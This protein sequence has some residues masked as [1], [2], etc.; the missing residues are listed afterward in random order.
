[1]L[2]TTT[3][4]LLALTAGVT[5]AASPTLASGAER[6]ITN[7]FERG[8]RGYHTFRIPA[9][10][11]C[12]DGT[13]LAFAEGRVTGGGDS[14]NIDLVMKRSADNGLTWGALQVVADFG[15]GTIGNPSA[16]VD[17]ASGAVILLLTASPDGCH[18][19]D[20]RSGKKGVRDP[21][22]MRSTDSGRRWTSPRA[23][24]EEGDRPDWRWYATGPGH[25]IQLTEGAHAG[26]IVAPANHSA[27][28]GS[29]NDQLGSHLLLSDDAGIT[30][31]IGAVD[32]SHVGDNIINPNECSVV[33][34]PDG[35]LYVSARDQHGTSEATRAHA[36]STDGGESFDAAFRAT[37]SLEG[38]VCQ[39]SLEGTSDGSMW[40]IG[41][42]DPSA[43]KRLALRW[44]SSRGRNWTEA[45]V[46]YEGA[47]AYSDLVE[48]GESNFGCLFEGDNYEWIGFTPITVPTGSGSTAG[49]SHDWLSLFNG[50]NLDGWTPKI[51]GQKL[52][53]DSLQTFRVKDGLLQ[54]NYDNYDQFEG[55]FGHLFFDSHFS[56]YNFRVEY[57][58]V[59]EQTPG[60]PG[61]AWRNSGVMIHGQSAESM[62]LDQDFPVSIEVQMLGGADTGERSTSNLCTPGTHVVFGEDLVKRHCTNSKSKT[63]RGDE[64]VIAE[65]EVRGN[66]LIRHTID[67]VSVLEYSKPQLDPSDGDAKSLIVDGNV[68]LTGGSISLQAESHPLEFRRVEIQVLED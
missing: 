5:S 26:R 58:F 62:T 45:A 51:K 38:P 54:V 21:Y 6:K 24:N 8:E 15:D 49:K 67:G 37:P 55:R 28:G 10:A 7:V 61:W 9:L 42:S 68:M 12:N 52:G 39:G 33:E 16:V 57:R 64:W 13:L 23:L 35:S 1:M 3:L 31:R 29:G 43:R 47:S 44:F 20:I 36:T 25:A 59:G 17:R 48:I 18:E 19:G 50:Q 56:H 2:L 40:F 53:D 14:G 41:P 22:V 66:E 27:S 32:D 63:Y 4:T 30:W 46:L 60:G 11:H 34:R 65:I